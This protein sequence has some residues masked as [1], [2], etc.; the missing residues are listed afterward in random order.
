V[1]P[2]PLAADAVTA[3]QAFWKRINSEFPGGK[4]VQEGDVT[5]PDVQFVSFFLSRAANI[6]G[7][8]LQKNNNL[9]VASQAFALALHFNPDNEVAFVN[10]KYNKNLV[11]GQTRPVE[12]DPNF[13]EKIR[14]KYRRW[15][16]LQRLNGPFDEP[17]FCMQWGENYALSDPPFIR[18][19]AHQFLRVLTLEPGNLEA[20]VWLAN[21]YLKWH[22]PDRTLEVVRNM[23]QQN[24]APALS[25]AN[26]HEL[27]RLEAW[28]YTFKTNVPQAIAILQNAQRRDPGEPSLPETL[29]QIYLQSADFTNSLAA[30]DQQLKLDPNN[31]KA[32][33]NHGALC[34]QL[35]RYPQ[36][37]VSLSRVL[38][39]EPKNEPARLNRAIANLQDGRLDD[40]EK[41]YDTLLKLMPDY[42]R[43][44]YGLGE[45]ARQRKDSAAAIRN[46]E[47]YMK[48]APPNTSETKKVSALLNEMRGAK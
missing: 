44:Y 32:L 19:A 20:A 40:A 47:Q 18:L 6:W 34:I 23:R 17:R 38:E 43:A 5:Q 14:Q 2:P 31:M 24:N 46:F 12:L 3:N 35:K 36:A 10:Q 16:D 28:A 7:V 41:D 27:E 25:L 4:S 29:A 45:I 13:D 39:S 1:T 22:L 26:Q 8:E 30:L 42:Y 48:F 33:F 9:P 15:T 11:A 21:M 37:V